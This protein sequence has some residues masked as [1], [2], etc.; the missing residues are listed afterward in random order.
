MIYN[1][2]AF[3]GL[4]LFDKRNSSTR[5]DCCKLSNHVHHNNSATEGMHVMSAEAEAAGEHYINNATLV[6]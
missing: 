3:V 1:N 6:V 5:C 4:Q 2:Y